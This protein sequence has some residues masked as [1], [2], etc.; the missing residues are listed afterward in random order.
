M[1]AHEGYVGKGG[2]CV[3]LLQLCT[4]LLYIVMCQ[5]YVQFTKIQPINMSV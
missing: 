3:F 2:W 4:Q 1:F 5:Y